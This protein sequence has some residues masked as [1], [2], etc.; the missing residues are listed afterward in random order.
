M[1]STHVK[2]H[3]LHLT[4]NHGLN[5][6][7]H[8]F[9]TALAKALEDGDTDPNIRVII[10]SGGEKAFSVGAA[11]DELIDLLPDE[12][13]HWL[14]PWEV[15][16]TLS[17]PII[18][19]LDGYV[20][21]G[22]L[23]IALMGDILIGTDRTLLGQPEIKLALLPGC[24]GTLRLTQILGYHR[25]FELC[26]TGELITAAKACD[27][28]LLNT[29]VRHEDLLKKAFEI[30][31]HIEKLSMPA[32]KATKKLLKKHYD[33][34][35]EHDHY[36]RSE[37]NTFKELLLLNDAHEGLRAFIEKRPPHFVHT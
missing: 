8:Q 29:V 33:S 3:I 16:A 24:G 25:T 17:K 14:A 26:V 28:G 22:G 6:L 5:K 2:G 18:M 37:R 19:A 7:S 10:V 34:S 21:G 12:I 9:S 15:V 23:E 30:G 11:L 35:P 32:V 1:I 27:Y 20:L 4:L 31:E 36:L 13:D